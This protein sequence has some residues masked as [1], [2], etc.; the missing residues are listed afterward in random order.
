MVAGM[1]RQPGL[2]QQPMVFEFKAKPPEP[3]PLPDEEL[4]HVIMPPPLMDTDKLQEFLEAQP[5]G[6]ERTSE[7]RG[8]HFTY[9]ELEYQGVLELLRDA[10]NRRRGQ[11]PEVVVDL[12]S[13]TG[14]VPLT[15]AA[16][17][18][19]IRRAVG[20]ELALDRH[21]TAIRAQSGL[22]TLAPTADIGTRTVLIQG[23]MLQAVA[24]VAAADVIWM[25]NTCY[26]PSL[27]SSLERLIDDYAPDGCLVYMCNQLRLKR[28]SGRTKSCNLK[29]SWVQSG[30]G[31]VACVVG[32]PTE[33]DF[34]EDAS[35]AD[36]AD[37]AFDRWAD[38]RSQV[39]EASVLRDAVCAA[40]LPEVAAEDLLQEL[41][42]AREESTEAMDLC[43]EAVL[44]SPEG[45]DREA[46]FQLCTDC[47]HVFHPP[48]N[49][50]NLFSAWLG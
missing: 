25:A 44:E 11:P 45:L 37:R 20:I 43:D 19:S 6:Y 1:M 15:A 39:L 40:L 27:N 4:R 48:C 24:A 29:V 2:L 26:G 30:P 16:I 50:Q 22:E 38:S 49:V 17:S 46:F 13:G 3:P 28:A 10:T 18:S 36:F 9:G 12:G 34:S 42:D 7:E 21:A 14:K 32:E 5:R 8:R 33:L 23:N 31:E 41:C 35:L 47:L